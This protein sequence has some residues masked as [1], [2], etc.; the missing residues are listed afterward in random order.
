M[1]AF[2]REPGPQFG[3]RDFR[4]PID[5]KLLRKQ[6]SQLVAI[7]KELGAQVKLIPASPDQPDGVSVDHAAV[8]LPE[9]AVITQPRGLSRESE[10]ETIATALANH[11]PIV[12][13][14]APACLD[15]RDVVRIGRTLFAGISRHTSAE[16]IA[17][18]AGTIEPYGYEVRTVEV[19]GCAHLKFACTF[20]PPHFLVANTS[21][22]DGNTF[23]DLVLIPVDEGEPFAANTLTVAGT[24]LVS[25]A[26]PKTEQRLRDAGIV[27]RGVQVSEFHKAEAGL[28]GLCLI[29][30][31]R[32]VRP[33]NAPVG[34][35]FVRAPRASANNGHFAQAVVHA[36]IV[37]VAGQ[38]PIDPKT[39]RPVEGAAEQQTEQALRNVATVLTESGSSLARVL[40][41]TLYVSDLKTLDGVNAACAR[42][43]AGHRP[44]QFVVPTK[45][46][47]Q[48]CLVAA[49][50]IAAVAAE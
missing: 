26:F 31:P 34:L 14:V 11:R 21:W 47:Q 13:I 7:L 38:L 45:P 32:S 22:V 33:A 20:V 39:G 19:H 2:L 30:E 29:L 23:G 4:A 43:F 8:V 40:R 18:F 1:I 35:R 5:L 46:L 42:V 10:V 17:E 9:V 50:V 12:R 6:H 3:V 44:A 48:G 24:T 36:G 37:Y 27:T 25:E 28:T 16:G 41:V 49:E 15:G